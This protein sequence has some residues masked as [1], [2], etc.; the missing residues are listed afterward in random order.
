GSCT[1]A[2]GKGKWRGRT[3]KSGVV[4]LVGRPSS[5]KS[6]LLNRITG[7]KVSIVS[8]VPQTT[9]NRIRGIF[10]S[11]TGQLVFID[12]PGYHRSDKKLNQ[13][14]QELVRE[15]LEE[16]EVVAYLA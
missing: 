16:V 2:T 11:E 10:T 15:A 7:H 4:A 13:R 1:A 14:L 8:P 6:T 12:T 9:R 3:M 5:G